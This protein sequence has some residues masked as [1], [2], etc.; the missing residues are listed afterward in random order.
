L[1]WDSDGFDCLSELLKAGADPFLKL[2]NNRPWFLVDLQWR[3][4]YWSG[5]GAVG[6]SVVRGLRELERL[7]VDFTQVDSD[8]YG[9]LDFNRAVWVGL[10]VGQP[11]FDW[12]R[13][14]FSSHPLLNIKNVLCQRSSPSSEFGKP[15]KVFIDF[16]NKS[17]PIARS[18]VLPRVMIDPENGGVLA[19]PVL[20]FSVTHSSDSEKK[21]YL[22]I[23][24]KGTNDYYSPISISLNLDLK[25]I[26]SDSQDWIG[27]QQAVCKV[28]VEVPAW[29]NVDRYYRLD[30]G[31]AGF[32]ELPSLEAPKFWGARQSSVS[33]MFETLQDF[34]EWPNDKKSS[35]LWSQDIEEGKHYFWTSKRSIKDIKKGQKISVNRSSKSPDQGPAEKVLSCE[36]F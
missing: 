11:L 16:G 34:K 18:F 21:D 9:F 22:V 24:S 12:I 1:Q 26:G 31:D 5:V 36:V 17:T 33:K 28:N 27:Y 6:T 15:Q 4:S 3:N 20:E 13:E 7:G 25:K 10:E 19:D 35:L 32:L 30:C 2:E 23:R 8:K 14:R 29:A